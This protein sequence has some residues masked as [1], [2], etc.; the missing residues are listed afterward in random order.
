VIIEIYTID[1]KLVQTIAAQ[2]GICHWD[3]RN[4]NGDKVSIGMYIYIVKMQAQRKVGK[5]TVIR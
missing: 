4:N 3:G 2:N 5:M 1:G